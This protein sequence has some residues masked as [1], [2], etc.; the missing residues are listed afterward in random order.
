MNEQEMIKS[1][2]NMKTWCKKHFIIGICDCP[3]AEG[4]KCAMYN[5]HPR[6]WEIP[7]PKPRITEFEYEYLKRF[8]KKYK[9]IARDNDSRLF[10][11]QNTPHK[12]SAAWEPVYLDFLELPLTDF[13]NFITWDDGELTCIQELIKE[14][15]EYQNAQ[16]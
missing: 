16:G 11:Y 8:D 3:F 9:Y 14:Y 12:S 13:L 4:R 2:E 6:S 15:E 10:A 1:A 7:K 5:A